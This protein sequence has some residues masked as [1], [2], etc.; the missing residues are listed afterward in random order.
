[1]S[2]T[3]KQVVP[4]GRNFDEYCRM[5]ALT[6]NE[7]ATRIVGC[8]EGPASFNAEATEKGFQIVSVDPIYR[9][10]AAQIEAWIRE[11]APTVA[12]QTRRNA[13]QF[14]WDQ[15]LTVEDLIAAR[16]AAMTK[17]FADY[18]KPDATERYVAAS[19]PDLP[20]PD[21]AFDLA[22]CSHFLFLYSEH[23]DADF[24]VRSILELARVAT[25]VRIFPLFELSSRPSRHLSA[26]IESLGSHGL[27]TSRITVPYEFQK[28]ANEML[29]VTG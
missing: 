6:N 27:T 25:E 19:L 14:V 3:L 18:S 15:F 5:F 29:K 28:G 26:V 9:F 10:P 12:Q 2:F 16:L 20:F 1:M 11:V 4:W 13:D 17:F 21:K 24:H 23:F 7:F 8:G 22:L